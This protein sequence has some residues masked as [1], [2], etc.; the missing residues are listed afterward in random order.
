MIAGI[1]DLPSVLD[2]PV[3]VEGNYL[4]ALVC[5]GCQRKPAQCTCERVQ[6]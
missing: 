3:I 2:N 1:G 6:Q 5:E 4:N